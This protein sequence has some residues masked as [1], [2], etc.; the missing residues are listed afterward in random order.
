[1]WKCR[2]S[3]ENRTAGKRCYYC[4]RLNPEPV[5]DVE[6]LSLGVGC[7][8]IAFLIA[9]AATMI[10]DAYQ[11]PALKHYGGIV[12]FLLMGLGMLIWARVDQTRGVTAGG[13]E[14][15]IKKKESPFGFWLCTVIMYAG[16][17]YLIVYAVI[18]F[19]FPS[20]VSLGH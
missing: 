4:R 13:D 11:I 19:L 1:M 6:R 18:S 2:C 7:I 15:D 20:I 3:T 8:I 10:G 9:V 16:G 17:I 12:F 5:K 14:F